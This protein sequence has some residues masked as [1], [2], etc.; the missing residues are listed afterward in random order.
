[1][2]NPFKKLTPYEQFLEDNP[3]FCGFGDLGPRNSTSIWRKSDGMLIGEFFYP[4]TGLCRPL[5][6]GFAP[7]AH[8]PRRQRS[9]LVENEM[10]QFPNTRRRNFPRPLPNPTFQAVGDNPRKTTYLRKLVLDNLGCLILVGMALFVGCFGG[11]FLIQFVGWGTMGRPH[12]ERE[13]P[14]E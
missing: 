2:N 6:T 10:N 11:A 13:D 9:R 7:Y 3:Q 14:G 12:F 4:P 8:P 5:I 1:M